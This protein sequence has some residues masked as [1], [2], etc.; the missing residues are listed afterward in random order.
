M[1]DP[2]RPPVQMGKLGEKLA[3]VRAQSP[4]E[5]EAVLSKMYERLGL[6][7][8]EVAA[9]L[10]HGR[11]VLAEADQ[12]KL[13][14]A[15]VVARLADL[16]PKGI[17]GKLDEETGKK[18]ARV[19]LSPLALQLIDGKSVELHE[20]QRPDALGEQLEDIR[21]MNLVNALV[22]NKK[23]IQA[24]A[25]I[26]GEAEREYAQLQAR[27][28]ALAARAIPILEEA[29]AAFKGGRW[30]SQATEQQLADVGRARKGIRE[31]RELIEARFLQKIR[32]VLS[33]KQIALVA[34][35]VPGTLP[36]KGPAKGKLAGEELEARL[37]EYMLSPQL[38][39]ILA[40]RTSAR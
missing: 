28:K 22:L 27:H 31:D 18:L 6:R 10:A 21:V 7:D 23:Q 40:R 11:K 1:V 26:N 38:G 14:P 12:A 25:E 13:A 2:A 3:R 20:Y 29:L 8:A 19:L 17:L 30:P 33:A 5:V 24:V 32:T 36:G 9:A 37:I 16:P 4:G 39:P 35:F 15:Q 34:V